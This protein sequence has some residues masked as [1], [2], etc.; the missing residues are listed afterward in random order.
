[1]KMMSLQRGSPMPEVHHLWPL[2]TYSPPSR[3][4]LDSMLVASDDATAGS[5]IAKAERIFPSRR[6]DS[7][8][9]VWAAV[10]YRTSTSMFPV[11]GAEQLKTSGAIGE[12]PMISHRGAYSRLVRP[13]PCSL[14]GKKR[15]QRPRS[16]ALALSSSMMGGT[17]QRDGPASSWSRNVCSAG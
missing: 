15:F 8:S 11:S 2:M 10:P 7:H 6:G 17:C 16:R 14:S 3:T 4:M 13:D 9:R 12:R 1:M 5:V